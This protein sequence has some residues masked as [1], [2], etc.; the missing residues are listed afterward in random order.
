MIRPAASK[1]GAAVRA[2]TG[3]GGTRRPAPYGINDRR[4]AASS[5]NWHTI[6]LQ[7]GPIAQ[8]FSHL[9]PD[10]LQTGGKQ[11]ALAIGEPV[12]RLGDE[13]VADA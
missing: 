9:G 11:F 1:S 13:V 12:K 7:S 6:H 10:L 3:V 4:S 5:F 2:S 8:N